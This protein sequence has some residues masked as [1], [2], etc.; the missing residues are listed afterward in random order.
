[1]SHR[2]NH[3]DDENLCRIRH[4]IVTIPPSQCG[5]ARR[6]SAAA[7]AWRLPASWHL[8]SLEVQ[9]FRRPRVTRRR[10]T[11]VDFQYPK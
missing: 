1:M 6:H 11:T 3:R 10:P 9:A 5:A 7:L 8:L 4:L 2:E